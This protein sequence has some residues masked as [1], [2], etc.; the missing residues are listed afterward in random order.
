MSNPAT[1][2]IVDDEVRSLEAL[3]RNL[4]DEFDVKT[5]SNVADA[6]DILNRDWVQI[7][8]CDQRMPE[9][10]GVE[11]LKE[12]RKKWPD[13]IRIIISGYT[14][15]DDIIESI[16]DAGIYQ[17]ITKP[18]HPD[19]L[20]LTLKNA[21]NLSEMQRQNELLAV[22][23]KM[24]SP[25]VKSLVADRKNNLRTVYQGNDCIIRSYDSPLND[26]CDLLHRFS[27]FD[28]SVLITGESGTGKELAARV[29]H[30]NSLRWNKP[31]VVEN[32]GALPDELLE[33]ELFGHK[34]G[35]FTGAVESHIGLFER[36]DGGTIFL[37][38]IGEISPAFQVKLLRVLQEGEIR[39]VGANKSRKVDV[40]VLAATNKDLEAEVEKGNF[41][42]D[43]YFRLAAVTI[44][45]P[46]LRERPDDVEVLAN[47]LL[48]KSMKELDKTVKGFSGEAL[49][50]LMAYQW[51]GNVREMQ[52]EIQR[53]LVMGVKGKI[54]GA[55][56]LLPKILYAA[57]QDDA[58]DLTLLSQTK[59]VLKARVEH[60][61]S[62]I[63]RETL[64]RHRWNK[65]RA[66]KE[67]GLSRVG[68]R[69]KLERYDLEKVEHIKVKEAV[70]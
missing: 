70:S 31:F 22:E 17:Y 57:P 40:R 19:S 39:P 63:L 52:N 43:L 27:T 61:E 67:L 68:L 34:R 36:A 66:A 56:L 37:D 49:A 42:K 28:I 47:F 6:E 46:P 54:L 55:D 53:M 60:F 5:A 30:Y 45:M 9:T 58:S 23:L 29:L 18:W 51:P 50:C 2:L 1:I 14:D 65:S 15:A 33:S 44:Y 41:R 16:N 38:E 12:V 20:M 26:V 69:S 4:S 59:G 25:R 3:E 10:T 64:I 62:C 13:V 21:L 24:T 32:C 7:I 8:L 48:E 35:S 11:F